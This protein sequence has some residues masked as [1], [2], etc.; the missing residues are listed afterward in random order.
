MSVRPAIARTKVGTFRVLADA[1]G[2]VWLGL[3]ESWEASLEGYLT[4]HG[5]EGVCDPDLEAR[6][7]QQLVEYGAGERKDFDLPLAAIGTSF[8]REVWAKLETIPFGVT[9]TYVEIARELG[10]PTASRAVG[11]ANGANPIPV[12]IPCHRVLATTGLGGYGGGLPLKQ[13]LLELEGA[14]QPAQP[15]LFS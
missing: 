4:R 3:P 6:A 2:I 8:Q 5:L 1:R 13:R 7:V 10:R 9:R 15:A 14:A 12:I 11:G